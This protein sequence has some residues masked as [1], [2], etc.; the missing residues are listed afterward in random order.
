MDPTLEPHG[1]LG[2][3]GGH[4]L[5]ALLLLADDEGGGAAAAPSPASPVAELA[6][7]AVTVQR[8]GQRSGTHRDAASSPLQAV[9]RSATGLLQ[10]KRRR[11]GSGDQE[12]GAWLNASFSLTYDAPRRSDELFL[13]GEAGSTTVVRNFMNPRRLALDATYGARARR[14]ERHRLLVEE[15]NLATLTSRH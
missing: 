13:V 8:T 1:A 12:R 9:V 2:D 6:S 5:A 14:G 10:L 3:L 4:A 7:C 15:T 11:H